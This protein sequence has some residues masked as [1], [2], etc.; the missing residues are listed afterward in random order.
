MGRYSSALNVC[1][2]FIHASTFGAYLAPKPKF[3]VEDVPDLTGKVIIVTGGNAGIGKAT[4]KVESSPLGFG[5][6]RADHFVTFARYSW[7][8]TR[9]CISLRE[10]RHV[11]K[12]PSQSCWQRPRRRLSGSIWTSLLSRV[13]R[14]QPPNS[15]GAL[16]SCD[17]LSHGF[18][19]E[20]F[21]EA[22]KPSYTSYSITRAND[23]CLPRY[24]RLGLTLFSVLC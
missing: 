14:R 4:C 19:P 2:R 3:T 20:S 11:P 15:I 12:L 7:R 8:R 23:I 9:R 24:Y 1:A 13:S 21:V 5:F 10:V 17:I 18:T 16:P 6:C 22:R